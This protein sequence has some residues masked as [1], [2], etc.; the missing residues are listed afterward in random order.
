MQRFV[1]VAVIIAT[2]VAALAGA[3]G[4]WRTEPNDA[5]AYLEVTIAPCA[6]D[7]GKLCGTITKAFTRAGEDPN[8]KYLGTLIVEDMKSAT[9]TQ[10]SG[11]TIWDPESGRTYRS[12]MTRKGDELDVEG[13]VTIICEGE[14][15]T[16]V[17]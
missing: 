6:S 3:A 15:W 12:T 7:A 10:Y 4:V 9:P 14:A 16:R 5:G 8:Y 11:G 13:C 17:E 2:P 1:L